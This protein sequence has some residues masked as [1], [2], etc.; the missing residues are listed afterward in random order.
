MVWLGVLFDF[1]LLGDVPILRSHFGFDN[2]LLFFLAY[3]Q[4]FGGK[5]IL[6]EDA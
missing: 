6:I 2:F 1:G 4:R 3:D 5:T